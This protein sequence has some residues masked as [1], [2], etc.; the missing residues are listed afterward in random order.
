MPYIHCAVS[1]FLAKYRTMSAVCHLRIHAFDGYSVHRIFVCFLL[2]IV[3]NIYTHR[4]SCIFMVDIFIYHSRCSADGLH[5]HRATHH[6]AVSGVAILCVRL[7]I[8]LSS[9]VLW[10]KERNYCRY[11]GTT[12][13]A[14][15]SSFLKPTVV[16]GRRSPYFNSTWN[17]FL[18]WPILIRNADFDI[19][20]LLVPQP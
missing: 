16:G 11:I 10:Q 5:F 7:S 8:R 4:M 12:L 9:R 17:L 3:L 1:H 15:P 20:P 6:S 19:F 13:Q 18:K 2:W 14:N